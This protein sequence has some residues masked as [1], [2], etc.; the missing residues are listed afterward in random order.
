MLIIFDGSELDFFTTR[1]DPEDYFEGV[2]AML[3]KFVNR[4][5]KQA[6]LFTE[7]K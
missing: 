7:W 5:D 1:V 2:V 4:S 6:R 3:A